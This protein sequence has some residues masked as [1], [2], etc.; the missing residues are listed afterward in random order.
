MKI[1]YTPNPLRTT[2]ELDEHEK[3][4]FWYK[5]KLERYEERMFS[6][7]FSLEDGEYFDIARA[8]NEV[9]PKYWLDDGREKIDQ[10][11]TE[12]QNYYINALL[13]IHMGDC[14]CCA[15]SCPKCHA[16]H[17]LGID[18]IKGLGKF[19][20]SKVFHVFWK[21][22]NPDPNSERTLDEVITLM[23]VP[24]KPVKGPAWDKFSQ[25]DFEVHI[26]R[27]QME[28]DRALAWLKRYRDEHFRG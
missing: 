23:D 13:D 18:T 17:L 20:G 8:R 25:A 7:H 4:E 12:Y 11:I 1:T 24:Y 22:N 21:D 9:D 19:E 14:T 16:E 3:K 28:H 10:H 5:L 27:W 15:S 6:A 2:V 26:P